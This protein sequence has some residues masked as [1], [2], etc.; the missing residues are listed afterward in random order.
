[1]LQR[2]CPDLQILAIPLRNKFRGI[3]IRE[4]AIFRGKQG[5]TE[6]SP[7]LEY[8]DE[9]SATWMQ[10]A[11]E[12]GNEPWPTLYRERVAINATLPIILPT[13]VREILRRFPGSSTVKV[14]VDDFESG[15]KVVHE[16][17]NLF[18]EMDCAS[19]SYKPVGL[20]PAFW[21][22]L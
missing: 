12:A 10:A 2:Y 13:Q 16:V 11:L 1:M 17:L 9:E 18:P 3:T 21:R 7:F 20:L 6:F 19:C 14:K 22:R 15:A 4:I 8:E 5:W